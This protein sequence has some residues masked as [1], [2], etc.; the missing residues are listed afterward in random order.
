MKR[1]LAAVKLDDESGFDATEI[2]D[3]GADRVL[4]AE[5][6]LRQPPVT[7]APPELSLRISL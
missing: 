2:R 3:E 7:Q 5:L 6:E 1:V 4:S